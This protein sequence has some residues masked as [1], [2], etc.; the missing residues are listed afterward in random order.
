MKTKIFLT[1]VSILA[2]FN[3]TMAQ[4]PQNAK[5][6][7]EPVYEKAEQMPQFPGGERKMMQFINTHLRYPSFAQ[8][9]GIQGLVTVEVIIEKN[10]AITI[11]G[12]KGQNDPSLVNEACRVVKVMPRFTP[13]RLNGEPVRVKYNIP[14]N[15]RLL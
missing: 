7:E 11:V 2:L 3:I 6:E 1:L 14:F 10:G 13:G 5:C 4:T 9:N 15:Y 12:T 8:E